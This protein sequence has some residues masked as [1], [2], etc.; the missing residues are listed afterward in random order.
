MENRIILNP[1]TDPEIAAGYEA[2]SQIEGQW[3]DTSEPMYV[4][5]NGRELHTQLGFQSVVI[6]LGMRP[7][8]ALVDALEQNEMEMY[9]IGDGVQSQKDLKATWEAFEVG[10]KM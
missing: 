6:A 4:L 10:L 3:A 8:R 5:R 2:W 1:F 7:N 9:V